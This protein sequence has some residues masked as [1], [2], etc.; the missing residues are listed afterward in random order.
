[1]I[2]SFAAGSAVPT[3]ISGARGGE[4]RTHGEIY[5]PRVYSLLRTE[6]RR[7]DAPDLLDG[8]GY[9]SKAAKCTYCG[10]PTHSCC[11]WRA[12]PGIIEASSTTLRNK[13]PHR[14]VAALRRRTILPEPERCLP[15]HRKASRMTAYLS[16]SELP[17]FEPQS[18]SESEG[19]ICENCGEKADVDDGCC[20]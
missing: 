11:K 8:A 18:A 10:D 5:I 9:V 2:A 13:S 6:Y 7:E 14:S 20:K 12:R 3:A 1:M 4:C 17:G 19:E 15:Q 16:E